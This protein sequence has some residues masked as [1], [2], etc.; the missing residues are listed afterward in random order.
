MAYNYGFNAAVD[1]FTYATASA[2]SSG[3]WWLDV[4][5]ANT[6]D[7]NTTNNART[8][9][10]ALDALT[11]EG[12]VAGIYSTG[13]QFSVI[14]G[15]FA[16]ATPVWMATGGDIQDAEGACGSGGA[17]GGG[18]TWLAQ[19]GTAGVPFDQDLA[20]TVD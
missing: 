15:D 10:G 18:T 2:A 1:A 14:A 19:Y 12:V 4:E 3:V 9:K 8:I 16:P 5:T 20:C 11:A 13:H 6:W 7:S 17:F